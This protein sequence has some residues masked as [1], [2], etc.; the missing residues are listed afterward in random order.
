MC[1]EE[2]CRCSFAVP[3]QSQPGPRL[4]PLACAPGLQSLHDKSVR[5]QLQDLP[6]IVCEVL[7]VWM[8]RLICCFRPA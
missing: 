7:K 3:D 5:I 4:T 2:E 6:P 1:V 8:A